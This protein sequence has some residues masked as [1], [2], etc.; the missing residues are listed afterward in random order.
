[1]TDHNQLSSVPP[2]FPPHPPGNNPF[3][4]HFNFNHRTQR[5]NA[6]LTATTMSKGLNKSDPVQL[7][8]SLSNEIQTL[9][10]VEIELQKKLRQGLEL[11]QE[12]EQQLEEH[13][14]VADTGTAV[15]TLGPL[16]QSIATLSSS[17][18]RKRKASSSS[19]GDEVDLKKKQKHTTESDD[20]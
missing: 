17:E 3:L 20:E 9:Q 18:L 5:Y 14:E 13:L 16:S 15:P 10:S 8:E 12:L 6:D 2:S 7:V 1:M 19:P 4:L 11:K